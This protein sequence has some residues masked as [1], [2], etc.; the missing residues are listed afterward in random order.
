MSVKLDGVAH[1]G[2]LLPPVPAK[3]NTLYSRGSFVDI[4]YCITR[5]L[6]EQETR[7]ERLWG[8]PNNKKK[9]PQNSITHT[10]KIVTFYI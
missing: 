1:K 2:S 8:S 4:V 5:T 10:K 3:P 9:P 7:S 6:A